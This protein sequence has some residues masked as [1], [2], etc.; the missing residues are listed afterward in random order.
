MSQVTRGRK[1]MTDASAVT[2]RDKSHE[3][4]HGY[5]GSSRHIA[6][7]FIMTSLQDTQCKNLPPPQCILPN[8]HDQFVSRVHVRTRNEFSE[9]F[10][11][12]Q[13]W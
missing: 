13:S 8:E 9:L 12:K 10:M 6:T 4:C 3:S 5:H 7:V 2:S 11:G 1:L